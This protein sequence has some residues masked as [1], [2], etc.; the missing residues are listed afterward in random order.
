VTDIETAKKVVNDFFVKQKAAQ[1]KEE[2]E[3]RLFVAH[4]LI[5]SVLM[6]N[7]GESRVA[8]KWEN[9]LSEIEERINTLRTA[10]AQSK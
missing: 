9:Q 2:V 3:Q 10:I 1:T 4:I 6:N 8:D 7:T 5:N